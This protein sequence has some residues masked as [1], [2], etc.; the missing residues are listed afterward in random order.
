MVGE[1][2]EATSELVLPE[3]KKYFR[4]GEVSEIVGVE[5]YVLRYWES[6]FRSV[7]P[8]KTSAG[9]RVYARKDVETLFKIRVLLHVERFS[10]KGAKRA[11]LKPSPTA[12]ITTTNPRYAS[13]LREM[14][15]DLK[16]L[17]QLAKQW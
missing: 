14:A 1:S 6:E 4:I 7:R 8:V 16:S 13:T 11:L 9:H 2:A 17:I 5:P 15:T 10:I 12:Q 3:G